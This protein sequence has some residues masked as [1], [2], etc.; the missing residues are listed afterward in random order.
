MTIKSSKE[1][2]NAIKKLVSG[3]NDLIYN[4]AYYFSCN[5]FDSNTLDSKEQNKIEKI[6]KDFEKKY[7]EHFKAVYK[8]I[9]YITKEKD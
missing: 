6:Y 5:Y 2:K 8:W 1:L 3:D 7:P 4:I 9:E